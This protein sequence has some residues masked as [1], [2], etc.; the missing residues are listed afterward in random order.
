MQEQGGWKL[1]W[2]PACGH[3]PNG[4]FNEM[5]VKKGNSKKKL[6]HN[7]IAA[8]SPICNGLQDSPGHCNLK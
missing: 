4:A 7:F 6:Q 8:D 1:L 5:Q 2:P 3:K